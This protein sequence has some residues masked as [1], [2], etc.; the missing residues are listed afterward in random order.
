MAH[1]GLTSARERQIFMA[2]VF[3]EITREGSPSLMHSWFWSEEKL[4]SNS[5]LNLFKLSQRQKGAQFGKENSHQLR[6]GRESEKSISFPYIFST[7]NEYLNIYWWKDQ[8]LRT[9]PLLPVCAIKQW[10]WACLMPVSAV[11]YTLGT[12]KQLQNRLKGDLSC[13]SHTLLVYGRN[14][15]QILTQVLRQDLGLNSHLTP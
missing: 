15:V 7:F 5:T 8:N 3:Q 6:H 13:M 1:L 11:I 10:D 9:L 4:K 12:V 14:P 2:Q